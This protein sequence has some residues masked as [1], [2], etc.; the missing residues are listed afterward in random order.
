[1]KMGYRIKNLNISLIINS[2]NNKL[3]NETRLMIKN[4]ILNHGLIIIENTKLHEKELI[5]FTNYKQTKILFNF[6][7]LY[8]NMLI[9]LLLLLWKAVFVFFSSN[10]VF[11]WLVQIDS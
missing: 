9:L 3:I 7:S 4:L 2:N 10:M 6:F 1:M 8:L 11:V 5:M